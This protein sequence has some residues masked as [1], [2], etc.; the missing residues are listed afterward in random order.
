MGQFLFINLFSFYGCSE[1]L[2]PEIIKMMN[3]HRQ[4]CIFKWKKLSSKFTPVAETEKHV[5]HCGGNFICI[6]GIG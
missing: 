5:G 4:K 1:S 2:C 3:T 6:P